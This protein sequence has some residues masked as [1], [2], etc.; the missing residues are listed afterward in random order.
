MSKLVRWVIIA[1]AVTAL[2]AVV[3]VLLLYNP[4]QKTS[5]VI[6]FSSGKAADVR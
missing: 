5:D 2:L 1:G 6:V 4:A 3:F